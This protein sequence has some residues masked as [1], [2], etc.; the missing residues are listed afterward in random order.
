[1]EIT[2]AQIW[3]ALVLTFINALLALA[4]IIVVAK[5]KNDR[6]DVMPVKVKSKDKGKD[7]YGTEE[8]E[9]SVYD[10]EDEEEYE[11]D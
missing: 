11:N 5:I 4:I 6:V 10:K 8:D 3:P 9:G 7:F 2:L 1:M